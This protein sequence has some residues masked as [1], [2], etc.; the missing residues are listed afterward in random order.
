MPYVTAIMITGKTTERFPMAMRAV[1]SFQDQTYPSRQLIILNDND[2]R[3]LPPAF[4]D[5]KVRE[6]QINPKRSLGRLRNLGIQLAAGS[7]YLVQWDDDDFSHPARLA[8]QINMMG[9]RQRAS[10]F[11]REIHANLHSRRAFA[12]DGMES[13]V[14]GFA[15]T[16]MWPADA[17]ARFPDAGKHEDTE[18]LLKLMKDM[19]L[20]VIDNPPELY[21]RFYHGH[22]T[23][24]ERHVMKRKKGAR[25]LSPAEQE[26]FDQ[27]FDTHYAEI[28]DYGR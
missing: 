14:N 18:F 16:M 19:A 22:N 5:D 4:Q 6:F 13:R 23:W 20:L 27:V 24:S 11:R 3:L 15:G 26:Y 12:N 1:K 28:S 7:K 25:D 2:Q 17:T 10:I 9:E 8:Y 21:L